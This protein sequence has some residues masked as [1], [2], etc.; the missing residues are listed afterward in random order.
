MN[1][2]HFKRMQLAFGGEEFGYP[3]KKTVFLFGNVTK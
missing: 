3:H 1:E 2:L